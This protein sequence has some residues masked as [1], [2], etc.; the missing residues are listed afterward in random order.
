MIMMKIS[1]LKPHPKNPRKHPDVLIDKL[2]KSIQEFGFTNPVLISK[3]NMILAGHARCKAAEKLGITEVPT[4][5]LDFEG[6]KADAYVILDNKLN[7]LSEWDN[8]L[9]LGMIKDI[10]ANN[11][12]VS[13]TGFDSD[14]LADL[15]AKMDNNEV[16]EDDFDVEKAIQ[17]ESFV[18]S[19]DLWHLGRHR[20]LCGDATKFED[21]QKL[22]K[23]REANLCVT[24]A[25]YNVNYS[26]S[27]GKILNDNMPKEQFYEFLHSSFKN[28]YESLVDGGAFYCF[29]SDTEKV[30][31]YNACVNSGFHHSS[32]CIWVKDSLVLGSHDYQQRHEPCLYAFKNTAK[33]KWYSDRKQTTIWE[34]ARPKKSDYHSTQKPLPLIAYPIKNSSAPNEI[35]LDSFSGSFSTGIVCHQMDR[36]CYAI[37]LDPAYVGASIK[38]FIETVGSSNDVFVERDGTMIPYDEIM[39]QV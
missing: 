32:T 39:K 2:Q 17:E 26:G 3:D 1:E 9:L 18:K 15:F 29:H 36:I 30:N 16:Q 38:R 24:D 19:G 13:L 8:D 25:P 22:M 23:G 21:M 34:F 10:E 31:F 20:L 6:A 35:V 12:D 11:F 33:H 14:E 27:K 5:K 4:I 37:E 28:I 7:E